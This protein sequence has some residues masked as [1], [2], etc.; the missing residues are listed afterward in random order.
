MT[1]ALIP[2]QE[3]HTKPNL[4]LQSHIQYV[5]LV[6]IRCTDQWSNLQAGLREWESLGFPASCITELLRDAGLIVQFLQ[7]CQ[8]PVCKLINHLFPSPAS[9]IKKKSDC[10]H[11]LFL[12]FLGWWESCFSGYHHCLPEPH[13]YAILFLNRI[14]I[15]MQSL[16]SRSW[17]VHKKCIMRS[18]VE[19]R[20]GNYCP[21]WLLLAMRM[22][23]HWLR[24][25]HMDLQRF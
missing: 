13:T 19:P 24:L 8:A 11:L 16:G 10:R 1:V 5:S 14:H 7:C 3:K 4:R 9:E 22:L 2:K 6:K 23:F 25:L 21:W 12:C 20:I 18:A 15:L 17:W